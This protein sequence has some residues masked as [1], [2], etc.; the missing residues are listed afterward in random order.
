MNLSFDR[1]SSA[2]MEKY[3]YPDLSRDDRD[4]YATCDAPVNVD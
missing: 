2:A 4:K 1:R 3:A